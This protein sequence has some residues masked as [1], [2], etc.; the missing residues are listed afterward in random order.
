LRNR[1]EAALEV[2][3]KLVLRA[4]RQDDIPSLIAIDGRI[5]G[6]AKPEYWRRKLAHYVTDDDAVPDPGNG[7]L[8]RIAEIDGKIVGFLIGEVRRWEFGQPASGW[9]TSLAV[10]PDWQQL[11]IGRR[12]LAELLAFY[13][14][15]S[16]PEVRTIVE[17]VDADLLRF[18]HSMGFMG[19]P[20]VELQKLL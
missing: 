7:I 11:G 1:K 8:T 20:Y 2:H 18:F 17:W 13:R 10:D 6:V 19:G 3:D 14:E 15:Q 5:S 12:L 16:L 4:L 9:I